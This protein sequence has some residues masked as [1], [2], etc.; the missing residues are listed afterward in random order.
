MRAATLSVF[1]LSVIVYFSIFFHNVYTVEG[2]FLSS[3]RNLVARCGDTHPQSQHG[4]GSRVGIEVEGSKV[5]SH[6]WL[7]MSLRPSK[8][9]WHSVSHKTKHKSEQALQFCMKKIVPYYC[10]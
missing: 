10:V 2:L 8:A 7:M 5:E 6:S 1:L 4:A 3:S 9:L